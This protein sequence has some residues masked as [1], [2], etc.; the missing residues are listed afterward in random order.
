MI[1][2]QDVKGAMEALGIKE[3]DSVIVH[4]SFKSLG[5]TEN[6]ADTV[7]K[8]LQA[9]VGESGT[10]IFPTL[11]QKDWEHVYENWTLDA[12]SDVGYLTNYFRK[13]PEALRSNQATHSVAAIGAQ[14]EYI[15][16]THGETGKR[17]GIFGDTPFS[18]DSPWEK[19]Y[20][21]N[22]K[23][24]LIGVGAIKTTFRHYAEYC[25]MERLLKIAEKSPEYERLKA[26]VWS[27]DRWRE[28]GV[29]VH[30]NSEYIQKMLETEG[31]IYY[32]KCGD[33][34]LI[35][36][37][38]KDFVDMCTEML[39]TQNYDALFQAEWACYK[40]SKTW[41]EEVLTIGQWNRTVYDEGYEREISEYFDKYLPEKIYDAH[42]HIS[43]DYKNETGYVGTPYGQYTEFN[44]KYLNRKISGGLIMPKPCNKNMT[45][46]QIEEENDYNIFL[47][48]QNELDAALVVSPYWTRDYVEDML[49]SYPC[50]KAF[51]P[52]FT[53]ARTKDVYESDLMD[54][55]PYWLWDLANARKMPLIIH[56]SHY[57]NMLNDERNWQQLRYVSKTYPNCKI[58]LAHC[59]MGHHV[60]KL[61]L[62]LEHIKDLKNIWF[63][64]SDISETMSVYY[65]LKTFGVERMMYGG[66]F[67]R[68][69]SVG[70]VPEDHKY[71]PLNN[72]QECLLALLEAC[73]LLEF[74]KEDIEK[75]FYGN[76]QELFSGK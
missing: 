52:Y 4:S 58:V 66:N 46:E 57:Q 42:V 38:A 63:D 10:V 15:T 19:M 64:C 11:C 73:E 75:I 54:Y 27:Y 7:V 60:R 62:G 35:M 24:I 31:N 47:A 40:Q 29:W 26:Q 25:Y 56:L 45:K 51:K 3:G 12:E 21:L 43:R 65:C 30:I 53:H 2:W 8:G 18:V 17:Y 67:C 74:G 13:L 72:G 1:A 33:A 41:I 36:F 23:V 49:K 32:G 55:V 69:V 61:R 16:S 68:A 34:S 14:A 6:G 71:Q 76:A 5:E 22:T 48:L 70:K 50:I 20:N 28:K 44:K 9:A 59:A 39:E 37:S